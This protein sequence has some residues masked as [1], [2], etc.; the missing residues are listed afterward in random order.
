MVQTDLEAAL[1]MSLALARG[2]KCP[3]IIAGSL[4]LVGAVR[5]LLVKE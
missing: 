4:Y 5:K 1:E 3:L 2:K